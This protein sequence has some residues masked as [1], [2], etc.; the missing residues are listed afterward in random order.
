MLARAGEDLA[1]ATAQTL[2]RLGLAGPV[3]FGGG[4]GMHSIR[5]QDAFRDALAAHGV[6]DIRVITHAPVFGIPQLVA[7][8]RAGMF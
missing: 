8:H 1:R 7:E 3:V 2:S 5:L 6:D 4:L